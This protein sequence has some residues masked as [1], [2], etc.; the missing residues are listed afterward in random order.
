M[1]LDDFSVFF[2]LNSYNFAHSNLQVRMNEPN[3]V[4]E[5]YIFFFATFSL[6]Y[7]NYRLLNGTENETVGI[8]EFFLNATHYFS[9]N[10]KYEKRRM[11]PNSFDLL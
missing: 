10:A 4:L 1:K 5:L 8:F 11:P 6:K 3:R 2:F 9:S 7:P